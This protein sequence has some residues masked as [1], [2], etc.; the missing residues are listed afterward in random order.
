MRKIVCI[1]SLLIVFGC[2]PNPDIPPSESTMDF[3][4]TPLPVREQKFKTYSLDEQYKVL[5]YGIQARHPPDGAV[6]L[7]FAE[8]GL[9]VIPFLIDKLRVTQDE[10]TIYA[11]IRVFSTMALKRRYDFSKDQEILTLLD[12]KAQGIQG[13][14]KDAVLRMISQVRTREFVPLPRQDFGLPL[15]KKEHLDSSIPVK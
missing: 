13:I 11:I 10:R 5:I 3:Y 6:V 7:W 12:Q 15:K 8:E 4:N 1:V 14:G 9:N 2:M